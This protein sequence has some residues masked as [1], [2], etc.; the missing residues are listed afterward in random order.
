[1]GAVRQ[2]W[3]VA[4]L[5]CAALFGCLGR[6]GGFGS[7]VPQGRSDTERGAMRYLALG[8]S[9]TIGEGVQVADRW[10]VQ[11]AALLRGRRVAIADP[12]IIARTGWTTAEL[13]IEIAR[14][15]PV[16]PFGLVTLLIGVNDQYRGLDADHYREQF[17]SA[18]RQAI[19]LAGDEAGRVIVLA[20][21]DWGVTPYAEGRDRARI[22]TEIDR[23]NAVNRRETDLAGAR[24][25]AIT[26]GTREA[27]SNPSLLAPDRLHPSGTM[28]ASW[29]RLAL[30]EALAALGEAA[31]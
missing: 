6:A 24:Y 9:Y 13:L 17:R 28:Y 29:A 12:I 30:P 7:A 20:I 15:D 14:Q 4:A 31:P 2:A 8:D 26:A 18:L 22:A 3:P 25:V 27:A 16:G 19:A 10:P 21:P 5:T 23:F 11:L 1:M